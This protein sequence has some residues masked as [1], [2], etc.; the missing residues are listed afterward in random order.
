LRQGLEQAASETLEIRPGPVR[1]LAV[2][3]GCL[4]FVAC[5]VFL[6]LTG[7]VLQ[8]AIG[9]VAGLF[10][11]WTLVRAIGRFRRHRAI[12]LSPSGLGP[13]MGGEIPWDDI[14]DVTTVKYRHNTLVGV[15]LSSRER[16]VASFSEAERRS[17]A[18]TNAVLRVFGGVFRPDIATDSGLSSVEGTMDFSR[19]EYGCDWTFGALELDRSPREFAALLREYADGR[20]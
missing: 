16:F 10:F 13:A 17:L 8:I 7:R 20:G 19:R 1:Q 14:H 11:A 12:V 9:V 4:L 15:R 5:G 18:R 6:V 3:A 2:V